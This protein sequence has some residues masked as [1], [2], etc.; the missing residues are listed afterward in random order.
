MNLKHLAMTVLALGALAMAPARAGDEIEL[1]HQIVTAFCAGCHAVEA[2]G[3]SPFADAPPFRELHK[4]YD[5]EALSE[6]LVEGIVT[7]HP[8][9]PAF[10]FTPQ[11][12]QAIIAY[13]KSLEPKLA[14]L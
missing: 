9:M 10:T 14:G 6:A 8:D 12:A 2:Q 3:A 4:R 1:G 7:G 11:E 13:L 5:V